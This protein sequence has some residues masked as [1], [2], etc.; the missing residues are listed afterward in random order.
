VS[1]IVYV[2]G[3]RPNFVKMAPVIRALTERLPDAR[4]VVVHTEQHYH[5][6][7]SSLFLDQLGI[8]PP[9]HSLGVGSGTHAQ[10]T[11]RALERI[12]SVL[13]DEAPDVA[14]VAGDVNSTLAAS[15]AAAK[16]E[17]P[18]AHI[19]S[20]L[21]SFDRSMPEEINRLLTDQ[22][23]A[24]CFTHSPEADENLLGEG[25][26]YDRIHQVGNTMIDTLV[27]S[28]P[29]IEESAALEHLE[30]DPGDYIL[31]TLH[32]PALVDGKLLTDSIGY[33][34]EVAETIPVVFP[35]HPRTASR[36][37]T[38]HRSARVKI[39]PPVGYFD[40][41]ALELHATAVLTDSGGVQE[42]TTFLRV[43]CFT[44]RENTERPITVTQGTNTLLGLQPARIADIPSL[45][46][47]AA[48]GRPPPAGWDGRAAERVADVIAG[49]LAGGLVAETAGQG[50]TRRPARRHH[51]TP[52]TSAHRSPQDGHRGR[53]GACSRFDDRH[54][55]GR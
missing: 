23:S 49:A 8:G 37:G 51:A 1:G 50:L 26:D 46:T 33:L 22:I 3:A 48:T 34:E 14:I 24:W 11:G 43:P 30:V 45:L 32:R 7:L 12:E 52:G 6:E 13:V 25:V 19:E 15:L 20:G 55:E 36:I 38:D 40:F 2:V 18:V 53:R 10:Q 5:R 47:E 21:R 31:V 54:S 39:V 4:H 17:I 27:R 9:H 41:V 16:L 35:M 42:E 28:R 44:L 29:H